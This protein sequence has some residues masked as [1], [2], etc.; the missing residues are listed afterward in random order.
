MELIQNSVYMG[1]FDHLTPLKIKVK[2]F[3]NSRI[4][5]D[6]KGFKNLAESDGCIHQNTLHG[7]CGAFKDWTPKESQTI[8]SHA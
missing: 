1:I 5:A 6:L 4:V 8:S 3:A 7:V 2:G